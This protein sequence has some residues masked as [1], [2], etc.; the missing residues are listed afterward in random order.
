MRPKFF[1]DFQSSN[2]HGTL[3]KSPFFQ[4]TCVL[5]A[6]FP[7]RRD[8]F[9]SGWKTA[10]V[11]VLLFEYGVWVGW[12][13]I[14]TFMW[15]AYSRDATLLLR[16][17]LGVGWDNNV[18]VT[19]VHTCYAA[20]TSV[21]GG[22]V[23]YGGRIIM[24]MWLAY[25]RD[26]LK[27]VLATHKHGRKSILVT[28]RAPC[29]PKLT[30]ENNLIHESCTYSKGIFCIKKIEKWGTLLVH[31]SGIDGMW[32]ISKGAVSSSWSTHK[33]GAVN[34]QLLQ[35]IRIWQWRWHH[36]NYKDFLSVTGHA[37]SKRLEKWDVQR[38]S[39]KRTL[40]QKH[41]TL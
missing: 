3:V 13:G 40:S 1:Q 18:H 31:T 9:P 26:A 4:K 16:Q 20:A 33:G 35:G 30:P 17:W 22:W 29:Y 8:V 21:V 39:K 28:D 37:L 34:P 6:R 36:G 38:K 27:C 25:T 24:F 23:G 11:V 32:K 41:K 14:I 5:W 7:V 10:R 12:G 19:C 15:L 2:Q